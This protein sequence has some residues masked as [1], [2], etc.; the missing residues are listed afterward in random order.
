MHRK[1]VTRADLI[2]AVRRKTRLSRAQ[3]T[4]MVELFLAEV[5]AC[6]ERGE[7][8]KLSSFASF[9][10]REKGARI[11]RNPKN[12]QPAVIARRRVLA[13]KPSVILK[14]EI[15]FNKSGQESK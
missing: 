9:L 11:G 14:R 8:V 12:G 2:E 6:L 10:V 13:F 4:A 1:T 7:D 15:N 5:T 3:A